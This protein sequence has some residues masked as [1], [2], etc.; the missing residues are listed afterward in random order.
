M[1]FLVKNGQEDKISLITVYYSL[2][3]V[4]CSLFTLHRLP[5]AFEQLRRI[6][7]PKLVNL[8]PSTEPVQLKNGNQKTLHTGPYLRSS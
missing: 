4:H 7:P 8:R 6:F 1:G 5:I 3:T 2:F